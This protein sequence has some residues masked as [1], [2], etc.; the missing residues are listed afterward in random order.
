MKPLVTSGQD[1]SWDLIQEV[2]EKIED[3]ALNKYKLNIYPNQLEIITSEQ[4]LDAYASHGLPIYYP[5]W[6][7]GEQYVKQLEAYKRGHMG[8][9]YEMV[10]NS[11]PCI[12]YLME[13]N[14]MLMQTLVIAHASFGHN[15]FFKNN[16]LMKQWTDAEAIIDYLTFAKKYICDCEEKYGINEVEQ[17]L[18][19]SHAVR[20]N[21]VFKYKR[22]SKLSAEQEEA[23]REERARY[24]QS[25]VNDLWR[26][27]PTVEGRP[28]KELEERYP[29]QPEE[30][31]LYFI[32]KN[33][34]RL[35]DWQREIIRIVR[36]TAQYFYPNIQTKTM[37]E[38]CA[39]YFHYKIMHDL[40]DMGIVDAGA[41]LEFYN[42]HTNVITQPQHSSTNPYTL[43]FAIFQD[44]ERV[45]MNPT[46]EDR[47]WFG[48][49]DWVGS[50][51][52]LSTIKWAIENFKDESFILQFLSPKVIRD[53]RLFAM[54]DDEKDPM[55]EVIAIHNDRGYRTIRETLAKEHNVGYIIPD[56][57]VWDVDRWGDRTLN[58]RH[59]MVDGVPLHNEMTGETI[60]YL[61]TLWGF[62][63]RLD[64]VDSTG[65]MRATWTASSD[66]PLL[67]IFL[68][69]D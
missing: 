42:V 51:D 43:G 67:D 65:N 27:V 3:L 33:A 7:F 13:E 49:Q 39:T 19:A 63:V 48:K 55:Y 25:L 12:A 21:S 24:N 2:T 29:K 54:R 66:G 1:W 6:S 15:H 31:I 62:P 68:E 32:E 58:L 10:I 16:Y 36:K 60:S 8:L 14:S 35:K 57:Q 46:N 30:N 59:T 52:Y 4:M 26:T 23:L 47:D 64:S 20:Y 56:I 53:L 17:I 38:G 50:G 40:H 61:S 9:A 69:D 11:S 45:A 5:H 28:I 37:N 34:P 41:M 22:P 18:D 44:I